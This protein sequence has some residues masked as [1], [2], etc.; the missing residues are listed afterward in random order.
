MRHSLLW[1]CALGAWLAACEPMPDVE[2]SACHN[3]EPAVAEI[4]TGDEN[5]G[6]KPTVDGDDALVT[7]GPQGLHMILISVKLTDF[8]TPSAGA[9]QSRL[10][11]SVRNQETLLGAIPA[12]ERPIA[13]DDKNVAFLGLRPVMTLDNVSEYF[14]KLSEVEVTI[15]DGCDRLIH[16]KRI[17]RLVQ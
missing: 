6:F 13:L 5:T 16:A 1:T 7:L 12:T 8:E 14:G 2:P 17:V 10:W 4:G 11:L 9:G 15:R 3:L